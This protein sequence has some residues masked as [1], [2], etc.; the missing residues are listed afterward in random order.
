MEE[1]DRLVEQKRQDLERTFTQKHNELIA[2]TELF[3]QTLK[4]LKRRGWDTHAQLWNIGLYLALHEKGRLHEKSWD[5][6][7]S[8]HAILFLRQFYRTEL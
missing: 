6:T 2:A 5:C 3:S 1:I 7:K 4:T 8:L